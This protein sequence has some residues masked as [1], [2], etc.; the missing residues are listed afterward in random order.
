RSAEAIDAAHKLRGTT[1]AEVA[2][3]VPLAEPYVPY[4]FLALTTFGRWEGILKG[5]MPP[6]DLSYS[7][8]LAQYARGVAYAANGRKAEAEASLDSLG[9]TRSTLNPG[10]ATAGRSTPGTAV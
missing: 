3:Q 5:P 4:V 1:P 6:R 10:Y 8:G 7:F 2:R 9:P